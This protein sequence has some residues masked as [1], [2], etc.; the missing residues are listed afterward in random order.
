MTMK[1][2]DTQEK[3]ALELLD[4]LYMSP[5]KRCCAI[6]GKTNF[7]KFDYTRNYLEGK[8]LKEYRNGK[9]TNGTY[10]VI[11]CSEKKYGPVTFAKLVE[12]Y[13]NIP[14]VIF[15]NCDKLLGKS[16][17]QRMFCHLLDDKQYD[18]SGGWAYVTKDD[19]YKQFKTT[20]SY[21]FLAGDNIL[22]ESLSD[23]PKNNLYN[24]EDYLRV[25]CMLV[26]VYDFSENGERYHT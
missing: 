11:D 24:R 20:S 7:D 6:I 16:E 2:N 23:G 17:I 25:F 10:I 21:I 12:K 5:T 8:D 15:N 22:S 26:S 13:Q 19:E 3:E 18:Y 4:F 14:F 1:M 9:T